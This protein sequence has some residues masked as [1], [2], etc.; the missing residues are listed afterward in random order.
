MAL[1]RVYV[2]TSKNSNLYRIYLL[3]TGDTEKQLIYKHFKSDLLE[4]VAHENEMCELNGAALIEDI[5]Y[6]IEF[7]SITEE[8]YLYSFK[9]E[10]EKLLV[11]PSEKVIQ[12]AKYGKLKGEVAN[13][14]E[15]EGIKFIIVQDEHSLYFL[16]ISN[17][18]I[19]KKKPVLSLSVTENTTVV[20]VPKGIQLPPAITARLER[21]TK[22][23]FVYDVNKFESMLTLNENRKAKS[24][25]VISKFINGEYTISTSNYNF[26]G[27]DDSNVKQKLFSSARAIRRLSKYSEPENHYTIDQIKQAVN[28]LNEDLRVTFDDENN[29]ILV[30]PETAKTFVGIIN[31]IIV[32][33]LIS[34]DIEIPI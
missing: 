23:L 15:N 29:A 32:E 31:N 21:A 16:A 5:P 13:F 8:S 2:C 27:L 28:R 7:S 10:I 33:R 4:K 1:E 6:F 17:N 26:K 19:I 24:Q 20:D 25:A 3:Q 14:E 11:N 34:G 30:T 22:K 12:F 9:E 18:S